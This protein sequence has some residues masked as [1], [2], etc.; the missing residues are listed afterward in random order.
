[1]QLHH[2]AASFPNWGIMVLSRQISSPGADTLIF[3][4]R[5]FA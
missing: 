2:R 5:R 1:M 3:P 4:A